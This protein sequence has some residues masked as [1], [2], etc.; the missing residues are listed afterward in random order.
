MSEEKFYKLLKVYPELNFLDK[1][2]YLEFN[3]NGVDLD[4]LIEVLKNSSNKEFFLTIIDDNG[5]PGEYELLPNI[6]DSNEESPKK[7]GH[8]QTVIFFRVKSKDFEKRLLFKIDEYLNSNSQYDTPNNEEYDN[9][10]IF[11][12]DEYDVEY[13]L[14][15]A[16]SLMDCLGFDNKD[17]EEIF[18]SDLEID[19]ITDLSNNPFVV[20]P[21]FEGDCS[22]FS[23][24]GYI[25]K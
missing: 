16:T 22:Q 4:K 14:G 17:Y 25:E 3:W 21:L 15:F 8:A 13:G 20:N 18:D 1:V 10:T 7:Y 24:L 2:S 6:E 11:L 9:F 12:E 19:N 23:Y 5:G